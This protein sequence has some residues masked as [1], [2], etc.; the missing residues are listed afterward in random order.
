MRCKP[1]LTVA[2]RQVCRAIIARVAF[3]SKKKR[4][5]TLEYRKRKNFFLCSPDLHGCLGTE[6]LLA[7]CATTHRENSLCKLRITPPQSGF[8]TCLVYSPSFLSPSSPPPHPCLCSATEFLG[9]LCLHLLCTVYETRESSGGSMV[10]SVCAAPSFFLLNLFFHSVKERLLA[11]LYLDTLSVFR[12][13][14]SPAHQLARSTRRPSNH[15]LPRMPSPYLFLRACLFS[16]VAT[17]GSSSF[18]EAPR[19]CRDEVRS[20]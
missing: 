6:P 5:S 18:A 7:H 15:D 3:S 4:A 16:F 9:I 12:P 1:T 19:G 17:D 2:R 8:H 11:V 14:L 20:A 13:H 10:V